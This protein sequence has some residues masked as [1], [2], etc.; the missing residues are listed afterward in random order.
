MPLDPNDDI[1]VSDP[2]AEMTDWL[3]DHESYLRLYSD[4]REIWENDP[5]FDTRSH[6]EKHGSREGRVPSPLFDVEYTRHRL[7]KYHTVDV[8]SGDVFAYFAALPTALRFVPNQVFSPWAF[9]HLYREEYPETETLSDYELFE[10]YLTNRVDEALS[11]NGVF[12]EKIY[13]ARYPDVAE[14]VEAGHQHSG[15]VH[16][17]AHGAYEVRSNLPGPGGPSPGWES[18]W[19]KTGQKGLAPVVW[20]FD[21]SFYL[22]VYPDVHELVR[23]S[24]V[25]SG[26]EHFLV[27]GFA[28]GRLPSPRLF[29]SM[30]ADPAA[31]PWQFFIELSA[32][33]PPGSSRISL[34]E[35]S[36]IMKALVASG[37]I[38]DRQSAAAALWPHVA[39]PEQRGTFDAELYLAV[40]TDVARTS[41]DSWNAAMGHWRD[42]GAK[43]NRLAPGTN[44]FSDRTI[45]FQDMLDWKSGV[46]FFGPV[47]ASSG[48][49][50]AARGYA[51]A[52]T[53]AGIPIDIY[54]T[55]WLVNPTIPPDLFCAEDLTYS[56]NFFCMNADQ[57]MSFALKYGAEIYSHRANVG[58]WVWELMSPRAEWRVILSAFDLILTPSQ[59]CTEAFSLITDCPVRTVPH[60][61]DAASLEA[62]RDRAGENYWNGRIAA[63]K[64]AGRRIVL[65]IMD[66]SSYTERKGVDL[67]YQLAARVDGAYP[68]KYRFVLKSHSRDW[69]S[70]R[71]EHPDDSVL[72]IHAMFDF[73][74]LCRLKS[75]ADL[76]VSPHRS[77]GFGLNIIESILLGVPVLC[78]DFAGAT[79][80]LAE[81]E[82]PLV[83]VMLRE[84]GRTMGP[85][86]SEGVWCEPSL[87]ALEAQLIAFFEGRVDYDRFWAVQ[88]HLRKSLSVTAVGAKLKGELQTWCALGAETG[89]DQIRAFRRIATARHDECFML[90][91]VKESTRRSPDS[92]GIE[93]LGEIAM[94]ALAPFFSIITPTYNSDPQWLYELYDDLLS[95]SFPS[96]EWCIADDCSTRPETRETLRELRRKDARV[97]VRFASE[98]RGISAATNAAVGFAQGRYVVMI[99][100]D[101]RVTPDL[102]GSYYGV[103]QNRKD[104]ALLYCDE[105]KIDLAGRYC[106]TYYK[107]DWSPEHLMSC[108]YILHCL[109]VRK[110]VFLELGGYR[111]AYD[112]AQDHDFALRAAASGVAIHHV[113]RLMYH[114]RMGAS[115][116]AGNSS[117]K[118]FA[119]EAGRRAVS[120]HLETM[121][122]E[123]TVDH[124]LI[125][126]TYR[127]RPR[128][129]SDRVALLILTGCTPCSTAWRSPGRPMLDGMAEGDDAMSF[130]TSQP[131][132]SGTYVEKFVRSILLRAPAVNFEIRVVVDRPVEAIAAPLADLDPRVVIV[133]FDKAGAHFNYAEKANFAVR[134]S[135]A[136]RMV[137]LNDDMETIDADW[138]PALMEM[139]E[140]PGVGVVGGRLLYADDTTQHCGIALGVLGPT[141][142]LFHGMALET[143]S[144]NAFNQIIR[145]YSAVTAAM[146]AFRRSTFEAA[147]GFDVRFPIDYNDV[148]FCLK[149][150]EAGLRV[151][152]TP[153]AQLRHYESRSAQRL[154]A[155]ALDRQRFSQR[156]AY[157]IARDPYYNRNLPRDNAN[158][159][160]VVVVDH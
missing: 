138:L 80:L 103:V 44:L 29:R 155:D 1:R 149:V 131:N 84:V 136:D 52:L 153:F 43:E 112:G 137:L 21:E 79:E 145:N 154:T 128:L 83:P 7:A 28:E 3:F 74:D 81:N 134:S 110:S 121:G 126:G 111:P 92:P 125:Q 61:V 130:E 36:A 70:N 148:D 54:D 115:S 49:G 71:N 116:A 23:R 39:V 157:L 99:D 124:G 10:F 8:A 107:P 51:A 104:G 57:V 114:W 89:G 65:F 123:A 59:F 85:Y 5:S 146:I 96:W 4:V 37:R 158:C 135:V 58:L 82:P 19:I 64:A 68:G 105:D 117:N 26:L 127:A 72:V 34:S 33:V 40:N 60:V 47:G 12:N 93:R 100:H 27:L 18:I 109:C 118:L 63:E 41:G 66:A 55:S 160:P 75:L 139:L 101:D 78:S 69:S 143:V 11:P 9:R 13:R 94:G 20:W 56:I 156:W 150:G 15:I 76:Y 42:Y 14:A 140:L 24:V 88:Q 141:A 67:F 91:Y 50:N 25:K 97:K 48:L 108:M 147:G 98:N 6:F 113:D 90:G 62:A 122:V 151:V 87:D 45:T 31:G 119:I 53:K 142:H 144:Y 133:P 32:D 30:P 159:D 16:F 86:A 152:Y 132:V 102:L 22:S 35:A 120:D 2:I 77:E 46:N 38:G 17:L 106:E 73:P 129:G 95:Q